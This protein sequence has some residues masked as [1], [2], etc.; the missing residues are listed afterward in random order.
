MT[1]MHLCFS[2]CSVDYMDEIGEMREKM[3]VE[4]EEKNET[5]WRY[6]ECSRFYIL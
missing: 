3:A 6:Y 5:L 2:V 4:N 1:C